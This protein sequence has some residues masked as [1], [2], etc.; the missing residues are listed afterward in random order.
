MKKSKFIL[1]FVSLIFLLNKNSHSQLKVDIAGVG[2]NQIP[3]SVARFNFESFSGLSISEVIRSDLTRSG[4]FRLVD[5]NKTI[6]N[7]NIDYSIWKSKGIEALVIGN[8]KNKKNNIYEINY[9][10]FDIVNANEISNSSITTELKFIR[11]AAHKIS[12]DIFEKMTGI[13]GAFSSK[14]AYISKLDKKYQ[15]NVADS[16]GK[17]PFTILE[18]T[19]PLISPTWSP[20]GDKIAYVSF[21]NKRK[22]IIFVQNLTNKKRFLVSN[23][24]GNNSAPAWS[25]DGKR[26]AV[27]LSIDGY[28]QIYTLNIN[29][30]NLK[31]LTSSRSINTEPCFSPDGKTIYFTSDRGGSPQIY[32]IDLNGNDIKRLTFNGNYNTSPVISPNGKTLAFI[33]RRSGKFQLYSM[34][35]FSLEELLL[36]KSS[37]NE[38]PSFAP[39]SR[40]ILYSTD[41]NG[42]KKLEVT[43]ID[44]NSRYTLSADSETIREPD[45][46]PFRK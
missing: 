17:N 18:S 24:K 38:S 3:I 15:L 13:K 6:K 1:I 21:E 41:K 20:D 36:S 19:E 39:N 35:L 5:N 32:R 26:L 12:D 8:I 34:N 33:S 43:S 23:F 44:G 42:Q 30:S 46:G 31:K 27:A 14:I 4:L 2:T 9:K 7:F 16:D 10:I 37:T 28:T 29:G 40:Y 45:W 22:P 25:P 11:F